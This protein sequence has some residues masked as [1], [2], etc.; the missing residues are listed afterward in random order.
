MSSIS[1]VNGFMCRSCEDISLARRNLDPANPTADPVV[2]QKLDPLAPPGA[3]ASSTVAIRPPV[4]A[5]SLGLL[6]R[7]A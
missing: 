4:A 6:D 5:G 1:I 7:Y 2:A 3:D